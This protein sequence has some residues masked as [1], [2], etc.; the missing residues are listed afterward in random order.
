MSPNRISGSRVMYLLSGLLMSGIGLL[1]ST[2]SAD[3]ET[4][5][6]P[7]PPHHGLD[8]FRNI[9]GTP[10]PHQ[11]LWPY[12]RMRLFEERFPSP[13]VGSGPHPVEPDL[14]CIERP[15]SDLQLTWIGHA[16]ALVQIS[17]RNILT[18]PVFADR[19]SPVRL[20]GN[21]RYSP[22]GL[23]RSE[24]PRIDAVVISHNHYDHLER[25]TVEYFGNSVQWLV[26]LGLKAW[27]ASLGVTRVTELD[28]WEHTDIDGMRF[29]LTPTQHWSRRGLNDTNQTLWGSWAMTF[30][31]RKVWF[32]GDTGYSRP[33]FREIGQRLGPFDL[34]LIPVG[35]YAPRSFMREKHVDPFEAVQIH[36]DIGAR[37]S[38]AIHWGTFVLTSEPVDEPPT[39]LH[40]A[41]MAAGL[42]EQTFRVLQPGET[43]VPPIGQHLATDASE[44]PDSG[45][46]PQHRVQ[47][48]NAQA[49]QAAT[50]SIHS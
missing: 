41:L 37:Q 33:L 21:K 40:A 36:R 7:R 34:A 49:A 3:G 25:S 2:F 11:G 8:G 45:Q 29:T 42:N 23:K 39:L 5:R 10:R 22:P 46:N 9:Y 30:A 43:L 48:C 47:P 15:T 13:A 50:T 17:G 44:H 19:A 28:W 12:L 4:V 20:F 38:V 26:P 14:A 18:D 24:L 27:F 6:N 31:G 16:S 1:V 35:G 32:G